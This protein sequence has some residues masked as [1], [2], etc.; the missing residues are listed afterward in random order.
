MDLATHTRN[1]PAVAGV[2]DT[3]GTSLDRLA[4]EAV[5]GV[6]ESLRNVLPA[7]EAAPVAVAAFSSSI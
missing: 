7:Q 2:V 3:R 4:G 1:I 6:T 5:A